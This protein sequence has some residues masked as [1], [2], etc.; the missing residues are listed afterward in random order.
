MVYLT[1]LED[2]ID[3]VYTFYSSL[4][5]RSQTIIDPTEYLNNS[6]VKTLP[7]EHSDIYKNFTSDELLVSL[8]RC[9]N[10]A[11]GPDGISFRL[12]K[13]VWKS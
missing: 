4:Y 9:G 12:L 7:L 13:A 8:K 3:A 10:T 2:K 6:V 1:S 11:A 5:D